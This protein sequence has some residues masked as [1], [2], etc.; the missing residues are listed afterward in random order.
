MTRF[1]L[2]QHPEPVPEDRVLVGDDDSHG[3]RRGGGPRHCTR[4][5]GPATTN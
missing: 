3:L 1:D 5:V 4:H 2:E